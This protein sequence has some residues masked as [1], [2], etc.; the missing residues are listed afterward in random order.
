MKNTDGY[1]LMT[2]VLLVILLGLLS[3]GYFLT[4]RN[5]I[6]TNRAINRS[7]TGTLAAEAGLAVRAPLLVPVL[8]SKPAPEGTPVDETSGTPPCTGN[9]VG[10]RDFACQTYTFNGRTVHTYLVPEVAARTGLRIPAN[11]PFGGLFNFERRYVV[12]SRAVNSDGTVEA[13]VGA[14]LKLREIPLFQF[15]A[16]FERDLEY[17]PGSGSTI[18]GP[19]HT[20]GR[21]YLNSNDGKLRFNSYVTASQGVYRGQ[22]AV[23]GYGGIIPS[24]GST[25]TCGGAQIYD[26]WTYRWLP[27]EYTPADCYNPSAIPENV[28][29]TTW[30]GRVTGNRA[31]VTAPVPDYTG[32][33]P[34]NRGWDAAD[35]RIVADIRG[36]SGNAKIEVRNADNTTNQALT[37]ALQNCNASSPTV[38]W[39]RDQAPGFYDGREAK[40]MATVEVDARNLLTCMHTTMK[41]SVAPLDDDTDGGLVWYFSVEGPDSDRLNNYAVRVRNGF[42]LWTNG[43]A[44]DAPG[45]R[46]LTVVTNQK[47]YVYGDWNIN[48]PRPSA[49]MADTLTVLTGNWLDSRSAQKVENRPAVTSYYN[50][51]VMANI[52]DSR[53]YW[54]SGH[55]QN[56]IRLLEDWRGKDFHWTGSMVSL[57]EPRTTGSAFRYWDPGSES[58]RWNDPTQAYYSVPRRFFNFDDRFS[59]PS[60]LPPITPVTTYVRVED[61]ERTYNR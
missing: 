35:L 3:T 7:A 29:R 56:F 28:L 22:K 40:Y 18:N 8:K 32:F 14:R 6:Q 60:G 46:G 5:D 54:N 43:S 44:N 15:N 58:A 61:L 50:F 59:T 52:A 27:S 11:Q 10:T 12:R 33:G 47:M 9:N 37:T 24:Q 20:N 45:I 16:Y 19:I 30:N 26:G 42:W 13:I 51:A 48:N 53:P 23:N 55:Q 49:F 21:L 25:I 17:S 39:T 57:G 4:T 41:G 34:G 36:N 1:I 2:S 38:W 31:V